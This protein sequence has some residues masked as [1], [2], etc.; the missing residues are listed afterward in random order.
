[1]K[2]QKLCI[3]HPCF[4]HPS[5]IICVYTLQVGKKSSVNRP[6]RM[7]LPLAAPSALA[8]AAVAT[9]IGGIPAVNRRVERRS[10][11]HTHTPRNPNPHTVEQVPAQRVRLPISA[12]L[13]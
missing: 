13:L 5:V 4:R 3:R 10:I 8:A 12:A 7:R 11:H 2:C 9:A 6:Q 1:M